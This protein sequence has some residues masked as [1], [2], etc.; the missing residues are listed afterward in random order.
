MEGVSVATTIKN[1]GNDGKVRSYT[2]RWRDPGGRQRE[3]TFKVRPGADSY[4]EAKAYANKVENDKL[5]GT[6]VSP[7][8]GRTLFGDYAKTWLETKRTHRRVNTADNYETNVRKHILPTFEARPLAGVRRNDIQRWV[9][10]RAK[11]EENPDGLAPATLKKVYGFAASIFREAVRDGYLAKS[12]CDRIELPIVEDEEA[13]PLTPEQLGAV[14]AA[15]SPRYRALIIAAA[16]NGM[17][18]GEL[19]GLTVDRVDFLRFKIKVDRQ[20]IGVKDGKPIF[21]PPKTAS[22]K[23]TVPLPQVVADALSAHLATCGEGPER[24]ILTNNN[25]YPIIRRHFYDAWKRGLS[26]I[27]MPEDTRFH[28][29]RHTFVSLL[30]KANESPKAIQRWVGHK[31]ITETM[32]TYGHL[33]EESEETARAAIDAA[34]QQ[35]LGGVSEQRSERE[36][37][38]KVSTTC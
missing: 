36:S 21:G 9:N 1:E 17:R 28:V 23:R 11:T 5:Q 30:I 20:L 13:T 16:G 19:L 7:K 8:L 29:L 4:K 27:G 33:Y 14:V 37:Q 10:A 15:I 24:L 6:Y 2:V 3:K 26:R 12:P 25:G 35:R 31:S 32:D 22:S 38:Q 18:Q 34:L